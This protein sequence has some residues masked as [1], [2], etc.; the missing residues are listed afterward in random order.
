[1]QNMGMTLKVRPT[2]AYGWKL[3]QEVILQSS[4][5]YEKN[6]KKWSPDKTQIIR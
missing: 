6:V 2:L 1:M 4:F 3:D 5:L